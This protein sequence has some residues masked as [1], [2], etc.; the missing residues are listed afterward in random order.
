MSIEKIPLIGCRM[1]GNST[2]SV[3]E[4]KKIDELLLNSSKQ[5][6]KIVLENLRT[7]LRTVDVVKTSFSDDD[8]AF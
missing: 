8:L 1:I 7:R 4:V 6:K 3:F 5:K 2:V